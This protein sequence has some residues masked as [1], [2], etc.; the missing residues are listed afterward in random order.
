MQ[1]NLKTGI[2]SKFRQIKNKKVGKNWKILENYLK[3]F[4]KIRACNKKQAIIKKST[5]NVKII[6]IYNK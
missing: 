6:I 5:I 4:T 1:Q 2:K 3:N